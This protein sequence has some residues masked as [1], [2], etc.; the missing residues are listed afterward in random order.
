MDEQARKAL[1]D[2]IFGW[3]WDKRSLGP[4]AAYSLM[5]DFIDRAKRR[6]VTE[7]GVTLKRGQ[8]RYVVKDILE[9]YRVSAQ[10]FRSLCNKL[11][12]MKLIKVQHQSNMKASIVTICNFNSYVPLERKSNKTSNKNLTEVQ[13]NIVS[14]SNKSVTNQYIGTRADAHVNN[15][16]KNIIYNNNKNNNIPERASAGA[17]ARASAHDAN[18]AASDRPPLFAEIAEASKDEAWLRTLADSY[19]VTL[20]SV[21]AMFGP[22]REECLNSG[23]ES[24]ESLADCKKHFHNWLRIQLRNKRQDGKASTH[25]APHGGKGIVFANTEPAI[26]IPTREENEAHYRACLIWARQNAEEEQV[27]RRKRQLQGA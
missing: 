20:E 22:F 6:Q 5:L 13:Q 4:G 1:R 24:H 15:N 25:A 3:Y 14:K 27:Q 17:R 12:N 26:A 19:H 11:S 23:K 10:A 8:Y 7:F 18:P 16:N 9:E 21:V 2:E